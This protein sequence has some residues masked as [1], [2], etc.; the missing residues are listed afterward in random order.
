MTE[1]AREEAA[2]AQ[3][4]LKQLQGSDSGQVGPVGVWIA[5]LPYQQ[6]IAVVVGILGLL[7]VLGPSTFTR[8]FLAIAGSA[9]GGLMVAGCASFFAAALGE[10][11][12]SASWLAAVRQLLEGDG[13]LLGYCVWAVMLALGVARWLVGFNCALWAVVDEVETD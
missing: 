13:L 3:E 4:E 8:G 6:V 5:E 11:Q 9:I 2:K 7:S 10:G 12:G 1:Q